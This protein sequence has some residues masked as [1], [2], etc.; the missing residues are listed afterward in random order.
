MSLFRSGFNYTTSG[1]QICVAKRSVKKRRAARAIPH[2]V[3]GAWRAWRMIVCT[4]RR[5]IGS[6]SYHRMMC[7]QLTIVAYRRRDARQEGGHIKCTL[8]E[9]IVYVS[10]TMLLESIQHLADVYGSTFTKLYCRVQNIK[11]ALCGRAR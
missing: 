8:V 5:R 2:I 9:T 1:C 11:P 6:I 7:T 10:I 3:L 4:Q